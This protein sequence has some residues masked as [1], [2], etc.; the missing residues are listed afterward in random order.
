[1]GL[2]SAAAVSVASTLSDLALAAAEAIR[3]AFR[4]GVT[5]GE[6]SRNL[7]HRSEDLP[8]GDSWAYVLLDTAVEEVERELDAVHADEV[9]E[10]N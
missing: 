6:V 3:V 9:S 10:P 4:L 2:C 8:R 1:M 7:Q 5:V